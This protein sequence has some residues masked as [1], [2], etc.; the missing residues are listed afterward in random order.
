[1]TESWAFIILYLVRPSKRLLYAHRS[2]SQPMHSPS[3]SFP[4]RSVPVPRA[5]PA[6]SCRGPSSCMAALPECIL[7]QP[8]CSSM[9]IEARYDS[10]IRYLTR[11][12]TQ[13]SGAKA[14]EEC[15]DSSQREPD[16]PP[17]SHLVNRLLFQLHRH[18]KEIMASRRRT[19]LKDSPGEMAS[20]ESRA[21][22]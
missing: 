14:W 5:A 21:F 2:L 19:A 9:G 4:A 11:R 8:A 16:R 1:M 13:W 22:W 7:R 15:V 20:P 18:F 3:V 6:L 17:S 10:Q 12:A